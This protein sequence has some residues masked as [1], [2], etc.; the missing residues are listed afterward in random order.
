MRTL[1]YAESHS[2]SEQFSAKTRNSAGAG[3]L[4]T[5]FRRAVERKFLLAIPMGV[6]IRTVFFS[7]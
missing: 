3:R 4:Y 1:L 7:Q 5:D 6:S 2:A